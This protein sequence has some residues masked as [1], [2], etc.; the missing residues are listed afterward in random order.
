VDVL[1]LAG[2]YTLRVLA[3]AA[4]IGNVP[5]F[6]LLAF[7]IFLF[8][9]LA[10]AKR[11]AELKVLLKQ[12]TERT[13]GRGYHATDIDALMSLGSAAGYMAVLILAL[14]INSPEIRA[15]YHRPEVIWFL[16][17]LLLYWVSRVWLGAHRGKLHDDPV[18]FAFKDRVS[19]LVMVL[20]AGIA[21][22][23]TFL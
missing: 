5:S 23:A 22:T 6:W 2:L 9:S 7:S 21:L 15:L 18:V 19:R 17:P 13:K 10:L 20:A 1:L 11:H 8:L 16:C 14:Y 4:A 12:G 3:G